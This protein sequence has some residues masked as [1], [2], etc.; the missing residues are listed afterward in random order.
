MIGIYMYENKRNHKKYVGQSTNIERRKY[1]HERWPSPYSRFDGEL[2]VIG[3]DNFNFVILEECSCDE[4]DE[5][6]DYWIKFYN[7]VEEGYNLIYGGQNYRGQA[8]PAAR[9]TDEDAQQIIILL[10]EHKLNNKQIAELFGVHSNTIDNIN[11]CKTW[12][13]LHD[14]KNNIRNEYR[15]ESDAK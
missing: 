7:S 3:K 11:R 6:E 1:E 14:Y 4:L 2:K 9:L 13:H 8:N 15:K 5:R 10:E 12:T